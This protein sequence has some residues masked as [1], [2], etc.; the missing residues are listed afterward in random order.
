MISIRKGELA[1]VGA[2][3]EIYAGAKEFMRRTGNMS[4][5]AGEYPGEREICRD[6]ADGNQYVGVD[7]EG[8]IVGA[9]A[10]IVGDDP[11]YAEIDGNWLN[12]EPYG[13]IHRIASSGKCRG[14]VARS[15]EFCLKAVDNIRIDTHRDNGPM[16]AALACEGFVPVGTIICAD[17][18]PREAFQLTKPLESRTHGDG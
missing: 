18:T 6:I 15:V 17:G 4:Q 10:F 1:D 2:V 16:L 9:F 5:W 13:T 3:A 8:D 12:D 11:T 14:W 7:E